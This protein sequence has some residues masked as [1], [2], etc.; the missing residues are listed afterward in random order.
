MSVGVSQAPAG[1]AAMEEQD[2]GYSRRQV[3]LVMSGLLA[4]VASLNLTVDTAA[5]DRI[6]E[7][8]DGLAAQ[9]WVTIAFLITS[10]VTMPFCGRLGDHYGRKRLFLIAAPD[11]RDAR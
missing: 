2:R 4:I 5:M 9:A 10:T 11:R 6:G 1:A 3:F 7:G 8:L